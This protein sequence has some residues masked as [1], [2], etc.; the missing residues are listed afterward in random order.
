MIEIRNL[1]KAFGKQMVL[2]NLNLNVRRGETKVVIGRSGVGKTVL[3]RNIV[4]LVR[5]DGGSIKINGIE[6]TDLSEKEYDRLRMEIGMVFQGG[7]LFDSMNVADNVAFVLNEFMNLDR[8]TVADKVRDSL[9]LVGLKDV[10]HL[11]PAQLSGGMRKRV[12]L[13]RVLCMEP[14]IILYD[15]PTTGVDPITAAAINHLI[16]E[17]RNKLKVT[18]I[19]VTHDMNSAYMVADSI[20]MFYK[21][22]IIADGAP[23]EIKNSKH[24][25]I[26]QFIHG[27]AH[28]P[29]TE[30]ESLIFGH[31]K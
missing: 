7:A 4:G 25:V 19:V 1:Y 26:R 27:E 6:V 23:E 31:V 13:A 14:H 28:G 21:G 8:K 16:I 24:P 12:S 5:P 17:L 18:S 11:M 9:S 20:A 30:D 15:E 3:L 29:I 22:Q 10:E 2:N